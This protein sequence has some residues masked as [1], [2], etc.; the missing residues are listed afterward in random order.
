MRVPMIA[1]VWKQVRLLA[2]GRRSGSREVRGNDRGLC[3][4]SRAS[5]GRPAPGLQRGP[6]LG[7]GL[8]HQR[9]RGSRYLVGD[10]LSV[11][12]IYWAAFAA[13]IKPLP[14]ELCPMLPWMRQLYDCTDPLVR[15]ATTPQ[16]LSHR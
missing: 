12:D 4:P 5:A 16:L 10:R 8:E 7:R 11:V 13:T 14:H 15:A 2:R 6:A 1:R 3:S 9:A